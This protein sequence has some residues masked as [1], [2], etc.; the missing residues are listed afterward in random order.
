MI[1]KHLMHASSPT[2]S[3]AKSQ[4]K[5]IRIDPSIR[6]DLLS[7][8]RSATPCFWKVCF[9][10]IR[11]LLPHFFLKRSILRGQKCWLDADKMRIMSPLKDVCEGRIF[12]CRKVRTVSN[13]CCFGQHDWAEKHLTIMSS[14]LTSPDHFPLWQPAFKWPAP[15]CYVA[16]CFWWK[17]LGNAFKKM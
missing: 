2:E 10:V 9:Q 13:F 6:G 17:P 4:I 5:N 11:S 7:H 12:R 3:H 14:D 15:G 1:T 8:Q 16:V